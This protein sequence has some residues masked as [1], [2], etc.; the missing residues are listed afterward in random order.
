MNKKNKN[1]NTFILIELF[2]IV[3]V[4]SACSFGASKR[5]LPALK[6]QAAF[7]TVSVQEPFSP[8]TAIQTRSAVPSLP[9]DNAIEY[10]IKATCGE[11]SVTQNQ[12]VSGNTIF[13]LE[14][15]PGQWEVQVI[16]KKS[17]TQISQTSQSSQANDDI[18]FGQQTV[19]VDEYGNYD[20]TVP[21]YFIESGTGNV[22]LEI[23][24]KET[25]IDRLLLCGTN[26]NLDKEYIRDS[27]G[28][29]HINESDIPAGTYS[30]LSL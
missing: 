9:S 11:K 14:I 24:V 4:F 19:F 29:I 2:T 1:N 20:I 5:G 7:I 21:V 25:D 3:T 28:I 8:L 15:E 6:P 10:E 12:P 17:E 13:R 27:E 22:Q 26:T 18:L 16:G 30:G 23:D